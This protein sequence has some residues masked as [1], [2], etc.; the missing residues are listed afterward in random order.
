MMKKTL[1]LPMN[2]STPFRYRSTHRATMEF[3]HL[4]VNI[5]MQR[6]VQQHAEK[7]QSHNQCTH[8]TMALAML[9]AIR[10]NLISSDNNSNQCN[11]T[12]LKVD[13]VERVTFAF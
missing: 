2:Y 5:R 7:K 11:E 10:Y 12:I 1:V 8:P 13:S 9:K 4:V 3:E 6:A